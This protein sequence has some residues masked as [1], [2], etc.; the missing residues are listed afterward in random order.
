MG[1]FGGNV[2][3]NLQGF[4]FSLFVLIEGGGLKFFSRAGSCK[5]K[6]FRELIF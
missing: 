2:F 4:C 3:P 5:G 1:G 6:F